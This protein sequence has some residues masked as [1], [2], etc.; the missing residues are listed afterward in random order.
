LTHCKEGDNFV[1]RIVTGD[2]TWVHHYQPQTKWKSMQWKHLSSP[3]AKKFRIQ[4][5]AG[6]LML[7]IFWGSQR[8]IL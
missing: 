6:T 5:F 3:F 8:P 2:E 7:T 1:Q 4:P